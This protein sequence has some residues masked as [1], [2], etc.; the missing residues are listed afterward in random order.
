MNFMPLRLNSSSLTCSI[1]ALATI[2]LTLVDMECQKLHMGD[3]PV[4]KLV[5]VSHTQSYLPSQSIRAKF[6]TE[7]FKLLLH[8]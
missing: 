6:F 3:W 7:I 8:D 4:V 2:I 5:T 1:C